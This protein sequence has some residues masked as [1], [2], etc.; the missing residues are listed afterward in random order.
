MGLSDMAKLVC[1]VALGLAAVVGC[2]EPGPDTEMVLGTGVTALSPLADGDTIDVFMGPQGGIHLF[3]SVRVLG[4]DPGDVTLPIDDPGQPIAHYV[5]TRENGEVIADFEQSSPLV[6][7]MEAMAAFELVGVAVRLI[8]P[9]VDPPTPA[10]VAGETLLLD[11]TV[12]DS[13]GISASS[14]VN[15]VAREGL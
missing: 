7:S 8:L 14:A 3:A 6:E 5:V 11:A 15:V 13:A 4:V 10:D 12:T 9:E 1:S 2:G